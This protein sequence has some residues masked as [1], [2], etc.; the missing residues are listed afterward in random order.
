MTLALVRH[1]FLV[2]CR[3]TE[4]RNKPFEVCDPQLAGFRVRVQPSG[5]VTF[6]CT[7]RNRD[8][9]RHRVIIGRHPAISAARARDEARKVLGQSAPAPTVLPSGSRDVPR[10]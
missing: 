3:F 4:P 10:R 2:G 5:V 8:G 7:Y 1:V 6:L 9:T